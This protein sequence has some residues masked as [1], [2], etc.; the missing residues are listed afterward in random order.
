MIFSTFSAC[1][2]AAER[3]GNLM[4]KRIPQARIVLMISLDWSIIP[5]LIIFILT[6]VALNYLL[7]KPVTRIQE[8]RA[9]RTTGLVAQ[10]QQDLA[11][12]M[13]LFDQYQATIKNARIEGYRLME[14]ARSEALIKRTYRR[15][16]SAAV[17]LSSRTLRSPELWR[18][19]P[20]GLRPREL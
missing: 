1:I 5:A 8:E 7:F 4:R 17:S 15:R 6:V 2:A 12:H 14:K 9:R 3:A 11:H 18:Q 10:T 16:R 13:Q 19:V 20:C